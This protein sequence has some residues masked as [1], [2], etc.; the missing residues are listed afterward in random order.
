MPRSAFGSRNSGS[1]TMREVRDVSPLWRGMP[2]L[3]GKSLSIRAI[4]RRG[5]RSFSSI[6]L[7]SSFHLVP[8]SGRTDTLV[9]REKP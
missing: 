4:T 6:I 8:V 7:Q 3:S 5:G 2:N 1:K 9:P